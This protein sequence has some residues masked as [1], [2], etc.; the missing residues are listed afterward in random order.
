MKVIYPQIDESQVKKIFQRK[1]LNRKKN[2]MKIQ[3]HYLPCYLFELCF[4]S[5]TGVKTIDVI[6]DGLRGKVRRILWPQ[7][8]H[9]DN[10]N[11][12][13]MVLDE[14]TA[15]EKVREETRWFS[16][17]FDLR[18][19]RKYRLESV[20]SLG[21]VGYPFWVVYYKKNGLYNFSVYEGLSGKKEDLFGKDIFFELFD[22]GPC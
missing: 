10:E 19:R 17:R 20:V 14:R 6:C 11:L 21:K 4:Q 2:I 18:I 9:P 1:L 15:L 22:K 7:P 16:F 5:K 13:K 8:V 3:V 12:E